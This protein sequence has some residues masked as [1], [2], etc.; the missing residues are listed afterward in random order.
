MFYSIYTKSKYIYNLQT[1]K[2]LN[3]NDLDFLSDMIGEEISLAP[4]I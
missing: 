3:Q 2:E 1:S 4:T